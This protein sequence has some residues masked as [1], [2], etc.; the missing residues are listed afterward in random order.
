MVINVNDVNGIFP[1]FFM[2][3]VQPARKAV[4]MAFRDDRSDRWTY[5]RCDRK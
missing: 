2:K 5:F 4:V 3:I 1:S